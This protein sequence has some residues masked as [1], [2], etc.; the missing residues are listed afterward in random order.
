L[1]LIDR[2]S[3]IVHNE[4]N[5][6]QTQ[7]DV[8]DVLEAYYK[9][10]R[11]RLIDSVYLQMVDHRLLS[12]PNSPLLLFSQ[13]W[14]LQLDAESLATI[15]GEPRRTQEKRER[16]EKQITDLKKVIGILR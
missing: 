3:E 6:E 9:V 11:K 16:L 15:A 10:A 12:G 2:V 13:D 14:V 8:C 4:S 5:A 1:T 7:Q